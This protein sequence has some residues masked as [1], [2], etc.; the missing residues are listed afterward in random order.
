MKKT[1]IKLGGSALEN[2]E[3][4]QE[5]ALLV[6]GLRQKGHMVFLVHGGGPAINRALEA[7]G[8]NWTFVN[9]QRRT[10]S[11]MMEIIDRVLS[12][13]VN[14]SVVNG[15][16]MAG[17]PAVGLS[18]A[19]DKILT[20]QQV[21]EDLGRVG[22]VTG[23]ELDPLLAIAQAGAVPVIAPLGYDA[24]GLRFNIN[25]DKAAAKIAS[26]L[27]AHELIF[28]TDQKGVLNE[29]KHLIR[30]ATP[31][32]VSEMIESGFIYGGMRVK[33]EAM[34]EALTEG[35][36]SIRVLHAHTASRIVEKKFVGTRLSFP[37][38]HFPQENITKSRY[39]N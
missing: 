27:K 11:E 24:N 21:S 37:K 25:A 2:L 28:L 38:N 3:T 30:R 8:L 4:Q 31:G 26:A 10:S 13:E 5:L 34:M 29:K 35:V 9:G 16:Q 32:D 33:V 20:C 12:R 17:I 6:A 39:A 19:G 1:V 36:L 23:V 15:L 18:G 7:S 14:S 22:T